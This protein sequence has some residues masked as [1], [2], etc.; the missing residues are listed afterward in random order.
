VG[1][2]FLSNRL[3]AVWHRAW[4]A[5]IAWHS[6]PEL[7]DLDWT[8]GLRGAVGLSIPAAIGLLANHLAWG[9]LCAFATLWILSCDVGVAYRQKAVALAG[10]GVDI[11]IAYSECKRQVEAIELG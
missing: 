6:D 4:R 3:R 1:S 7:K 8:E 11:L 2:K 5:F 10:A 9:I